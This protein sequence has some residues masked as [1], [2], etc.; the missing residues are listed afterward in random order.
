MTA[1]ILIAS[2][3]LAAWFYLVVAHGGFWRASVRDDR[4]TPAEPGRWPSV[5]AVVPAREEADVIG[6][7]LGSL[8]S[9][10]Y[11]GS[12]RVILVDDQSQDGTAAVALRT[13]TRIGQ[14][15]HLTALSGRALPAGWAGKVWAMK[16]GID[17][18]NDLPDPPD[19][20][21]LTDADIAF[22][23]HSLR[24]LVAR[25]AAGDLTLASLMVKLRCDSFAERGFVPAFV[26]FFQMLYPFPWVQ[27]QDRST[28]AAA[29][30]CMLVRRDA[31][32]AAG[33]I[34]TIRDA[35][36][37][38]CALGKRL[39]SIGPIWLGLT[40]SVRSLRRYAHI[41]DIRHMVAR[42]A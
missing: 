31:L 1:S 25:A 12:F 36:I 32:G 7:S 23:G 24:L 37:D 20:L 42:S 17:R 14:R 27:R 2:T 33:G 16:Q 35:L 15:R 4:D 9:Q 11:P 29:G 6:E 5:V 3:A 41:G 30:G 13:A 39:K 22:A 38:D 28:A 34:E 21:L 19:Y 40:Q 10:E 18:A 8:L 26:F